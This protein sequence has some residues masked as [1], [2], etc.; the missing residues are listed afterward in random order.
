MLE[1]IMIA[2]FVAAMGCFVVVGVGA[3]AVMAL[4]RD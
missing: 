4:F 1:T 2:G 3:A